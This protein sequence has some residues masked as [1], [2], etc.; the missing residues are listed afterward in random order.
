MQS[1]DAAPKSRKHGRM[2]VGAITNFFT[3]PHNPRQWWQ[4]LFAELLSAYLLTLVAA[5]ADV[6]G[7]ATE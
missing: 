3:D 4:R 7:A 6:I 5:G 2:D 1:R